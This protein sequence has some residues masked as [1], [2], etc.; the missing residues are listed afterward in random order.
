MRKAISQHHL[1][2]VEAGISPP[3]SPATNAM[4][5]DIRQCL[6][7]P[8]FA[9]VLCTKISGTYLHACRAQSLHLKCMKNGRYAYLGSRVITTIMTVMIEVAQTKFEIG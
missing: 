7:V 4:T 2:P 8:A 9:P 3:W 6:W 5:C 1:T